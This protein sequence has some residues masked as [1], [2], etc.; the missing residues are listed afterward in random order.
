MAMQI[1]IDTIEQ[2]HRAIKTAKCIRIQV[3]FG[4]SERWLKI[5]KVQALELIEDMGNSTPR[6]AEMYSGT[7]GALDKYGTLYLG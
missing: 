4:F 1:D 6:E 3:R 7:F 5:T 2:L